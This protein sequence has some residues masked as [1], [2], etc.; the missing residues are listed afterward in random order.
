MFHYHVIIVTSSL[1]TLVTSDVTH[2][3]HTFNDC[4]TVLESA[5]SLYLSSL[6]TLFDLLSVIRECDDMSKFYSFYFV[7]STNS[8][9]PHKNIF[10]S[11]HLK[12]WKVISTSDFYF[13]LS[14]KSN[15][16]YKKFAFC[17]ATRQNLSVLYQN[18]I[19][20]IFVEVESQM[21]LLSS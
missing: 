9:R 5:F 6:P 4:I 19:K 15:Q 2:S 20:R 21:N 17:D 11:R 10:E 1:V 8:L 12:I 16:I 7:C 14:T 3:T 18:W 13:F